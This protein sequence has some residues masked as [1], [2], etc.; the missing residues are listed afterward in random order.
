MAL[1]RLKSVADYLQQCVGDVKFDDIQRTQF[2][3]LVLEVQKVKYLTHGT[4]AE[5]V[6]I[7]KN[8]QLTDAMKDDVLKNVNAKVAFDP[9]ASPSRVV[10]Q[11]WSHFPLF[12]TTSDWLRLTNPSLQSQALTHHLKC[13]LHCLYSLGLR[14][15]HEETYAMMTV[16]LLLNDQQR[17]NDIV[18]LRSVYLSCK[19][20][21]KSWLTV[22]K[23]KTEQPAL[24]PLQILP[25]S[26]DGLE[27]ERVKMVYGDG[28]PAALPQ[29]ITLEAL[30][31]LASLVP[32]RS[33]RSG[34]TIQLPP[35]TNSFLPRRRSM[36]AYTGGRAFGV[37]TTYI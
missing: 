31:H 3:L 4:A 10:L 26:P 18:A 22:L 16:L 34:M 25:D 32:L 30:M 5:M 11:K 37:E 23:N 1:E 29:Q 36:P 35:A 9:A 28:G 8:M 21:A 20:Q 12:L 19:T 15:P 14:H 13:M 17:F 27:K 6:P 2:D 33:T 7:I 24:P